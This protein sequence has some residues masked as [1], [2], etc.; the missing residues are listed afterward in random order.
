MNNI[1]YELILNI[2]IS[3]LFFA[4]AQNLIEIIREIIGRILSWFYYKY[5]LP[6]SFSTFYRDFLR[7]II[8]AVMFILSGVGLSYVLYYYTENKKNNNLKNIKKN[9]KNE[10]TQDNIVDLLKNY[11]KYY[12]I[13]EK[14]TSF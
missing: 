2:L 6:K 4:A 14:S 7:P 8:M 10:I 9:I 3:Q 13:T 1:P 12:E 11:V 5:D